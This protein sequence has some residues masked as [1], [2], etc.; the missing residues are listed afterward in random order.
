[1]N[2]LLHPVYFPNIVTFAALVQ[3]EVVW[4]Q[5]DNYQK[6]TYRN[7]CHIGT[8]QGKHMMNIPIVHVGGAQGRQKYKEVK[9]DLNDPWKRIH[10]KTLQTAYRSSPY[11]EFYEDEI[12]PLYQQR[13]KFLLDFNLASIEV[14]TQCLEIEMPQEKTHDYSPEFVEGNDG[15]KLVL[16][17]KGMYIKTPKYH[18]VFTER[19]G[20]IENLSVLDLLFNQGP[21][22]LTYLETL[23]LPASY[24]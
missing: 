1:M 18:Q 10:W 20:F 22:A 24:D 8:D 13:Q 11:F 2:L 3:N 15:R 9:I 16:A 17:K 21:N 12:A 7:R 6:Q 4:E 19:H 5:H 14:I 23:S